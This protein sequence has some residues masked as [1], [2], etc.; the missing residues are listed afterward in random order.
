MS[1]KIDVWLNADGGNDIYATIEVEDDATD[2]VIEKE[3]KQAIFNYVDW[4]WV[5]QEGE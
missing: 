2:E 5:E 4:G 1:R 3:A